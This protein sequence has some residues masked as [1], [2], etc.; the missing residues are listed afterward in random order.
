MYQVIE[1]AG[2]DSECDIAE[3]ATLEEA[4]RFVEKQ[5]PHE[6]AYVCGVDILY[7]GSTEY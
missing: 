6:E 4:Q 1:N 7:N 5:Y 3:F 2:R